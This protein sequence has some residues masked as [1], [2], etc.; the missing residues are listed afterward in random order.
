M[1]DLPPDNDPDQSRPSGSGNV[2]ERAGEIFLVVRELSVAAR[3]EAIDRF[4]AD[5]PELKNAV[6]LLLRG[7]NAPLPVESLADD[8]RAAR[9][10]GPTLES[11]TS[12]AATDHIGNYK[13]LERIGEGCFAIVFM[14]EQERPVRR[15]V[16]LKII[17][18]GMDTKQVVA[19]FEAERQALALMDHPSIAK[20]FD[21]GATETGRPFFVM[22]L[23]RGLPIT[24][25]CDQHRL[26]IRDRLSLVT[27][28][29]DALQHAHQRGVIHRDIKP[30]NV[31]VAD[32]GGKPV[33]KVIDFGIAKATS[34]RL[35]EK[36][37]FTEFRQMIGTPEYMS[38]EQAGQSNQDIDT[39]TDVYAVGVLLYELLTGATPFDSKRLRSAAF[40]EMQRIIREEDPPKPSTRL[41]TK[42]E[43]LGTVASHRS[44]PQAKLTSAIA[45][46]LDWIVMKSLEKDRTRRYHSAGSMAADI[47]RYLTGHAIEAAPPSKAYLFRKFVRRNKGPV[48]AGSLLTFA[49]LAGLVGTSVGFFRADRERTVAVKERTR[50]DQKAADALASEVIAQ[51]NAYGANL[52]SACGAL[53][54]HQPAIAAAFLEAAPRR[55]RGW[56]WKMVHAALDTSIRSLPCPLH[57]AEPGDTVWEYTLIPHADGRSFF[58]TSRTHEPGVQRWETTSGKLLATFPHPNPG[59][60]GEPKHEALH[61]LS[62]DGSSISSAIGLL[63]NSPSSVVTSWNLSD[64]RIQRFA[65]PPLNNSQGLLAIHPDGRHVL[66]TNSGEIWLQNLITGEVTARAQLKPVDT[67]FPTYSTDGSRYAAI[68]AQGEVVILDG[69]TLAVIARLKGHRNMVHNVDFSRDNRRV[70][71]AAIDGTAQ[72]YDL[73]SSGSVEILPTLVLDHSAAVENARFSPDGSLLATL[74]GDRAIRIWDI[75]PQGVLRGSARALGRTAADLRATFTSPNLISMPLM[76]MPD[77][78]TVAGREA[79]GKVRFWDITSEDGIKLRKHTGLL[80]GARFAPKN[81]LIVSIAWDGWKGASGCVRLWD[82]DTGADIASFGEPGEVPYSLDVSRDGDRAAIVFMMTD[83]PWTSKDRIHEGRLEIIDLQTGQRKRIVYGRI[84]QHDGADNADAIAF[85]PPGNSLA[86]CRFDLLEILDAQTGEVLRTRSLSSLGEQLTSAAYSPDGK[87][88]AVSFRTSHSLRADKPVHYILLDAAT[89][90]VVHSLDAPLGRAVTFSPDSKHLYT[91]SSGGEICVFDSSSG[92]RLT[93]FQAHSKIIMS[94]ALNADGSR[95]SSIGDNEGD[96]SIWDT[97]HFPEFDRVARLNVNEF[98]SNAQWTRSDNGIERL[99]ASTGNAVRIFEPLPIRNRVEA[100]KVRTAAL[101]SIT[102]LVQRLFAEITD[103]AKVIA[104]INADT[105]LTPLERKTALQE[106]LRN[107]LERNSV[108]NQK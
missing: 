43:T 95:L 51:R 88:L 76:F 22:E 26:S 9:E 40:G 19:R 83:S 80:N 20:V 103:P 66:R 67:V 37:I 38:P 104:A 71:T 60:L 64:E 15:R 10:A 11:A 96:I 16:A 108:S 18:L 27:Q 54:S 61:A 30:S 100:R 97:S 92:D 47:Q 33:P 42:P 2:F 69:N 90:Q 3:D 31:L 23:V 59:P 62:F 78:T 35:T 29:C 53:E 74:A 102:P 32:L 41:A 89:L 55:L 4:C 49:L 68:Y 65:L 73:P 21:A 93:S 84:A 56:E 106:V 8:I 45:G 63:Q 72:V 70:A 58:T 107:S 1:P 91:G 77:G 52:L 36:T 57:A 17:K 98:V 5:N 13:L 14:A 44:L 6:L 105:A 46:E 34:A 87:F 86:V 12:V 81:S 79:D 7:H 101:A 48:I 99:I 24:E 94:L 75:S 82:A 85:D 28:V 50:A 25:F 39:R